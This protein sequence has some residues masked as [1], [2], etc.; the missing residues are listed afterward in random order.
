MSQRIEHKGRGLG[1]DTTFTHLMVG[2]LVQVGLKDKEVE[3]KLI[4]TWHEGGWN[5]IFQIEGVE[6]DLEKIMEEW[7][8]QLDRMVA[9][10]AKK[11]VD[12]KLGDIFETLDDSVKGVRKLMVQKVEDTLGLKLQDEE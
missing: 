9:E 6:V 2:A 11:L 4:E 12:T 8:K 7:E 10:E 1:V 5:Y 3:K